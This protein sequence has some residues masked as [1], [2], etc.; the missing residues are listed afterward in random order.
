MA[1]EPTSKFAM[2]TGNAFGA[3]TRWVQTLLG[4]T[5]FT[6]EETLA[7]AKNIDPR[8]VP[9]APM[10]SSDIDTNLLIELSKLGMKHGKLVS[11]QSHPE[12]MEAWRTMSARAGFK[13]PPQLII[14]ESKVINA[15]TVSPEEVVLTT[16]LL[17][18]LDLR[19]VCAVLGHELG[20]AASDHKRPRIAATVA[21]GGAGAYAGH[22]LWEDFGERPY[23][24][25][26]PNAHA[27]NYALGLA[28]IFVGST[29]GGVV[30][31][32]VSVKPTELQA[33]LRGAAISGDPLG[34]VS[35]LRKLE[36]SRER[37]P[38]THMLAHLQSGYPSTKQRIA[39]L[40]RVAAQMPIHPVQS[41]VTV[42]AEAAPAVVALAQ[43]TPQVTSIT[44]DV[45]VGT[46]L[47]PQASL[48]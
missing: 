28:S 16:G 9:K 38:L 46:D 34:L 1:L 13:R 4:E 42:L 48:S 20:H 11:D 5:R 29:L 43:P 3:A 15:M 40:E 32:Q 26:R 6:P 37:S 2:W 36:A 7:D 22:K 33:D 47:T 35:A 12:L 44:P 17:K 30:A 41:S 25:K 10:Q 39:N 18:K 45:R 23:L 24:Q 8:L 21:F 14:V 31:N 27:S 19:E